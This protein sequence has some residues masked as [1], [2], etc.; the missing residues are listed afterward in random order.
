MKNVKILF[1]ILLLG[2]S[3]LSAQNPKREFRGAWIATVTNLDWPIT[4]GT[5]A[6]QQKKELITLLDSLKSAGINAVIFQ[7]RSECDAMYPSALEPW[8][9]WLT[10]QQGLA[11]SYDPLQFA[12]EE[13]H[14]RGMELHAWFNP[15]RAERSVGSYTLAPTHVLV[16]N[17][18][19]A[20][21]IGN[22][23]FLN[24]GLPAVRDYVLSVIL[25]VEALRC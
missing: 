18:E 24:P 22:I 3:T 9:Y 4:R 13:A 5:N 23:R 8:S 21:R 17:P 11:P 15:Y 16:E 19:W 20:L 10:G 12:I 7:I 1:L 2:L 25:D 14:K 6:T